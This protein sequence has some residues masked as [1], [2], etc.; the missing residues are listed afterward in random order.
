MENRFPHHCFSTI[1]IGTEILRE[2]GIHVNLLFL[3]HEAAIFLKF[4][5]S[6]SCYGIIFSGISYP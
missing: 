4:F 3:K 1:L 5:F 2:V 6:F